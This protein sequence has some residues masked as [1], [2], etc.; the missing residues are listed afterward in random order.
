M[1]ADERATSAV[2]HNVALLNEPG[3]RQINVSRFSKL[4]RP[5]VGLAAG[6]APRFQVPIRRYLPLGAVYDDLALGRRLEQDALVVRAYTLRS[7]ASLARAGPVRPIDRVRTPTMLLAGERDRLFPL[8]YI[9]SICARLTCQKEL[10]VVKD[11]GHM[12]FVEYV[13]Q[14]LPFVVDW[15]NRTLR[16]P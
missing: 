8:T 15:F 1:A 6:L 4:V 5:L 7:F 3:S 12:L 10:A 11:A 13:D 16:R 9:E 14:A 2:L